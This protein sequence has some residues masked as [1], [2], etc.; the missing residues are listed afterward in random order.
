M[1]LFWLIVLAVLGFVVFSLLA[2]GR[3]G[4]QM[5]DQV[6]AWDVRQ[7]AYKKGP[8][9]EVEIEAVGSKRSDWVIQRAIGP[10]RDTAVAEALQIAAIIHGHRVGEIL[11]GDSTVIKDLPRELTEANFLE[12]LPECGYWKP[13]SKNWRDEEYILEGSVPWV[14]E[15]FGLE[16]TIL[17]FYDHVSEGTFGEMYDYLVALAKDASG[18]GSPSR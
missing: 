14:A 9:C 3:R 1:S 12:A 15:Y 11:L 2:A 18:P 6:L 17:S 8:W 10:D 4:N 5:T 16:G 13:R 7:E